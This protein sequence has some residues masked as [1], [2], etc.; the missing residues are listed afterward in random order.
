MRIVQRARALPIA[1]LYSSK[2]C[3]STATC[4]RSVVVERL[5]GPKL[6]RLAR[7]IEAEDDADRHGEADR[8]LHNAH[9]HR[10]RHA[11]H[12]LQRVHEQRAQRQADQAA[13]AGD[14][15]CLDQELQENVAPLGA[16]GLADADLAR[17]LGDGYEHDVHDADAAY[18]QRDAGDAAQ[19]QREGAAGLLHGREHLA[20]VHDR[21]AAVVL[22][23]AVEVAF[24]VRLR[25]VDAGGVRSRDADGRDGCVLQHPL[26]ERERHD[27]HGVGGCAAGRALA[28]QHADDAELA[29]VD[30][31]RVAHDVRRAE[32]VLRDVHA[33]D[34]HGAAVVDIRLDNVPA[35]RDALVADLLIAGQHA[36]DRRAGVDVARLD[37]QRAADRGRH[38]GDGVAVLPGEHVVGRQ[39][40]RAALVAAVEPAETAKPAR[41]ARLNADG[42]Q[43]CAHALDGGC[44]RRGRPLADGHEHHDGHDADDDAQHR[45]AGARLVGTDGLE[46]HGDGLHED[47]TIASLSEAGLITRPSWM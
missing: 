46:R 32:Q 41:R 6:R 33:H 1:S 39:D 37:G 4:A 14:D 25:G 45:Q 18:E 34:A 21:V 20:L 5:D 17:A 47:H 35:R 16:H 22:V 3:T 7:R 28:L 31:Q 10:Q 43:V 8:Q 36:H 15:D 29:P 11:Q 44:D 27:D 42:Q 19:H 40:D 13:Q 9:G 24:D 38:G 12:A 23:A 30:G 2:T 26:S